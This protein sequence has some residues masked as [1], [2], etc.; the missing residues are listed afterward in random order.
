MTLKKLL[1]LDVNGLLIDTYFHKEPLPEESPDARVGNFYVYKRP[2]CEEFLQFCL[3]NFIVGIWSSAREYNVNNLVDYVFGDAKERLAFSWHQSDCTDVGLKAPD[4]E[5]KPLFMKDLSK[6]WKREKLNLPW[7]E[8]D[9]GPSNT[10]LVDDTPYKA[11]LNPPNTAIFPRTYTA[12]EHGD[13]FLGGPLRSY[14]EGIRNAASVQTYVEN[15]PFGEPSITPESPLWSHVSKVL[16]KVQSVLNKVSD[17]IAPVLP[18]EAVSNDM[19]GRG[20]RKRWRHRKWND[21]SGPLQ[22]TN[23]DAR[24]FNDFPSEAVELQS[25]ENSTGLSKEFHDS[26]V[27]EQAYKPGQ[28]RNERDVFLGLQKADEEQSKD[29]QPR[30]ERLHMDSDKKDGDR[31]MNRETGSSLQQEVRGAF[32]GAA[33]GPQDSVGLSEFHDSAV[34]EQAYKPGQSGN[35]SDVYSGLQKADEDQC[36]DEQPRLESLHTDSGKKDGDGKR[37]RKL[38]S[39]LQQE[40][41]GAFEGAAEGPIERG[42]C[43]EQDDEIDGPGNENGQK[44]CGDSGFNPSKSDCMQVEDNGECL[45]EKQELIIRRDNS[46]A[47]TS[48]I[49]EGLHDNLFH[50]DCSRDGYGRF[51][52]EPI[53]SYNKKRYHS[54]DSIGH[55]H[56]R[57]RQRGCYSNGSERDRDCGNY[58]DGERCY[59]DRSRDSMSRGKDQK[60]GGRHH[61]VT[62]S[63]SGQ[64]RH[65][66]N[67]R[68]TTHEADQGY[69][70]RD[71]S[72][73]R[74]ARRSQQR[75]DNIRVNNP[76]EDH[77][78]NTSALR[79]AVIDSNFSSQP[80]KSNGIL[81]QVPGGFRSSHQGHNGFEPRAVYKSSNA[82]PGRMEDRNSQGWLRDMAENRPQRTEDRNPRGWH[83]DSGKNHSQR[84][85]DWNVQ[86]WHRDSAENRTRTQKT[87]DWHLEG[88]PL[89]LAKRDSGDLSKPYRSSKAYSQ[90]H[91]GAPRWPSQKSN[92]ASLEW[93]HSN[94]D[95]QRK[96]RG[97]Y[98]SRQS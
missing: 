31:K 17:E 75:H 15:N 56:N 23:D 26:A 34:V 21:Y 44:G 14:L 97:F 24:L 70:N 42:H 62:T 86:Q 98:R 1:V 64:R 27:V 92:G 45:D 53:A 35:E 25:S 46:F 90:S 67:I 49:N 28:S 20:R 37:N 9:Y 60:R 32:E 38:S 59:Q 95:G 61:G 79:K 50:S 91:S 63:M 69:V 48:N 87:E 3:E 2:F 51:Q 30:L 52:G 96:E 82:C 83:L 5:W 81:G 80:Y 41:R 78:G 76:V 94:G 39:I 12:R 43:E 7:S 18:V 84:T 11:V 40:V 29:E 85:E 55:H 66:N 77:W 88:W 89:D 54:R 58:W 8:G 93:H 68:R 19:F 10:L 16:L 65:I 36:K 4:N 71:T 13:D 73:N 57:K 47:C 33:E 22:L 6:L 74:Y 72:F